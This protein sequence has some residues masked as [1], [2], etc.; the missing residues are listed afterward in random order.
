LRYVSYTDPNT[1]NYFLPGFE[2]ILC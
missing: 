1:K 2:P